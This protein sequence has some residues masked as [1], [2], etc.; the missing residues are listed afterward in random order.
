MTRVQTL[1]QQQE[2]RMV[3]LMTLTFLTTPLFALLA[4]GAAIAS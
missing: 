1:V 4:A 3:S 2:D